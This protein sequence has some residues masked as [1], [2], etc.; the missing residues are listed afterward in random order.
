MPRH[1]YVGVNNTLLYR[2]S[3]EN[4]GI[5]H[6]IL[7][8]VEDK[9]LTDLGIL[10]GDVIWLKKVSTAWWN[11]PDVKRKQSN[12]ATSEDEQPVKRVAYQKQFHGRGGARFTGLLMRPG[13]PPLL[14]YDL[15]YFCD[16]QNQWLPIPHGFIV[17]EDGEPSQL[18]L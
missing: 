2:S 12:T 13:S 15:L 14:D 17:A 8:D 16:V 18:A 4:N 10:P 7:P 5:G 1:T 11:G 3:L 9:F 6:D